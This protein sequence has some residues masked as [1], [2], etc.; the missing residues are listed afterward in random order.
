MN[1]VNIIL[2]GFLFLLSLVFFKALFSQ[3]NLPVPSDTIVGLYYPFRDI[4][5]KTNPNGVPYKNFLITDP[6]RQQIPWK[7]LVVEAERQFK[8]PIWNP[9]NFGGT[10]LLAN[11]QSGALSPFNLLFFVLPFSSAWSLIIFLQ[12]LL[13]GV[14]L[15]FYLSNLKLNKFAC[16]FGA[17]TFSFSGFSIAW[18]EWGTIMG[19]A[20]WLPLVLLSIDMIFESLKVK[21]SNIKI[22]SWCLVFIFSIVSSFFAGHLQTFFYLAILSGFYF[23]LRLMQNAKKIQ[24]LFLFLILSVLFLVS[25][26]PQLI[27][28]LQF[29]VQS[30]RNVDLV[31]WKQIGWFIPWQN[32]I[33]FVVPDFFGN[34]TTLNYYGIWNYGEF[35]G[36]IGILPLLMAFF[37]LFFRRDK[38]TLFF[39]SAFFLSLIFAF[40]TIF[41]KLPF[42]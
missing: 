28:T 20:L 37:A 29:I 35:I 7:T 30:G 11:F 33:Q 9:Y 4:F 8:L 15:L 38:K 16:L 2:I 23:L 32:L 18:M 24:S 42:E 27:P 21:T 1:K 34:P 40:A 3:G 6:V 10:P 22:I 12:P 39:G 26:L 13:A 31:G 14:F 17:I 25:I 41:A 5:A 19:T 36:Y